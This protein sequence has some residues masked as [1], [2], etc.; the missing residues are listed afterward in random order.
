MSHFH[1]LIKH[2]V[3]APLK[4]QSALF[5][6]PSVWET[7]W[8][9]QRTFPTHTLIRVF[10]EEEKLTSSP[11]AWKSPPSVEQSLFFSD[12]KS[13]TLK[14]LNLGPNW[15]QAPPQGARPIT[16][17]LA[18]VKMVLSRFFFNILNTKNSSSHQSDFTKKPSSKDKRHVK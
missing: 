16:R 11:R 1:Q 9:H 15:V 10:T 3:A 14:I 12:T 4:E 6:L 18:E 13:S 5:K 2:K 7:T 17:S 8:I